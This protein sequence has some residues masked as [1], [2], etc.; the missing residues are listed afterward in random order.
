MAQERV[1][2]PPGAEPAVGDKIEYPLL[3]GSK[4]DRGFSRGPLS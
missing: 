3:D 4:E 1:V 2:T